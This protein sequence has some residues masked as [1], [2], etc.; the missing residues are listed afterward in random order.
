MGTS[1]SRSG[2]GKPTIPDPPQAPPPEY[3]GGEQTWMLHLVVQLGKDM[4]VVGTKVDA[5]HTSFDSVKTKVEDLT[6]WK[7][8]VIGG[9]VVVFG[10]GG[11]FGYGAKML[12]EAMA[13]RPATPQALQ[14]APPQ[15]ALPPAPAPAASR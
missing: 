9:A 6:A 13:A 1:G 4:A 14:P 11:V 8:K 5:L 7:N 2:T 15:A 3:S 12:I 10:L